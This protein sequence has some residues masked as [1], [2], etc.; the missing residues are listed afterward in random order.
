[1]MN[2]IFRLA[3]LCALTLSA[4][5][6]VHAQTLRLSTQANAP[7]PW[8]DAAQVLRDDVLEATDG[9]IKIEIFN[10][11]ALG[12][13]ATAL[14]EM[15]MGTI[16]LLVGGTQEATPF[17]PQFQL[18]SLSYLF[19]DAEVLR[20]AVAPDSAISAYFE[21]VYV[22]SGNGLKLLALTGGGVRN[23]SNNTR[24]VEKIDDI[25]G[26]RMRVPG[27]R[28]DALMWETSGALPTSLPFT[29]LYTGMQT[30]VVDAFE[31][32]ISAYVANKLYEVAPYHAKTEHQFMVSH[33]TMSQ[34][35]FDRLS[36][37]DQAALMKAAAHASEVA[38]D[39]GI[40]YDESLLEPLV[41]SGQVTLTE[42]DKAP[43]IAIVAPLHD[44]V[45]ADLG[46]TD[47][48]ELIRS[49]H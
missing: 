1:M 21:D 23:L 9:R 42:V 13:D 25:S 8:L 30:G 34:A 3:A 11:G 41:K 10:G 43:F 33:I 27:S 44:E 26:M 39:A 29:E 47:L 24:P 6:P 18:F 19:A 28:M 45:A 38:I 12:N 4:A 2:T 22:Q 31:S 16:D 46:V 49:I 32:T 36:Q 37:D 7:H 48:L 15:R 35:S 40:K 14:D 17:F 5:V 20:T